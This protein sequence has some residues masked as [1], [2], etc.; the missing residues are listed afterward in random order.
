MGRY[1]YGPS[2]Y[3]HTIAGFKN[4][5]LAN[6]DRM[7]QDFNTAVREIAYNLG[8]ES[9][10]YQTAINY[11]GSIL[12]DRLRANAPYTSR[13]V[14]RYEKHSRKKRGEKKIIA[15][16]MPGNLKRSIKVLRHMNDRRNVYVGVEIQPVGQ[17]G[18]TFS[19]DRTDGYYVRWL[20]YKPGTKPFFRT[21][22]TA[23]KGEVMAKLD[24]YVQKVL[25]DEWKKMRSYQIEL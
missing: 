2:K 3:V 22:I 16:Y 20:E 9:R 5:S 18:G 21:T 14:Y 8:P 7:I 10:E 1:S 23:T 19:G 25:R 12:R 15:V 17:G 11:A 24:A 6:V 4:A 13:P